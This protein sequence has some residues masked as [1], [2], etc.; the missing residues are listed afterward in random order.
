MLYDHSYKQPYIHSMVQIATYVS[1]L[2]CAYQFSQSTYVH[3][4]SPCK[5][6]DLNCSL[7]ITAC[8]VEYGGHAKVGWM[9]YHRVQH[10][11]SDL[12]PS[13]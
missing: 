4:M 1:C 5:H 7:L 11:C 3:A 12:L 9:V 8:K 10:I 13:T 6:Y 2:G